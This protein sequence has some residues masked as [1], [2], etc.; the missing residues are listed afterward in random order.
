MSQEMSRSDAYRF[1]GARIYRIRSD[2]DDNF[3]GALVNGNTENEDLTGLVS[4]KITI[5]RVT[6]I[7]AENLA[8]TIAF[9]RTDDF[10]NADYDVDSYNGEV[11]FVAA[12]GVRMNAGTYTQ[13]YYDS[14]AIEMPYEDEDGTGELHV[15]YVCRDAAGKSAGTTGAVVVIVHYS[16]VAEE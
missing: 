5:H 13:Y 3:T 9:F 11:Q 6:V 12:D 10:Q 8:L 2:K 16:P 15:A 7:S 4:D 14:G 1:E